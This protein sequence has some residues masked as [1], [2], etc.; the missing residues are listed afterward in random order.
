MKNKIKM[1]ILLVCVA[2]AI[3]SSVIYVS[4]VGN[5]YTLHTN[6]FLETDRVPETEVK[7]SNESVVQMTEARMENGELIFEFET[8]KPGKTTFNINYKYDN[9]IPMH[10]RTFEVNSFGTLIDRT[11]GNIRFN[12]FKFILYASLAVLFVVQFIMLWIFSDYRKEGNFS[13]PM[14]ACGGIGI[15]NLV[16][17]AYILYKMLH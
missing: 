6:I 4:A 2:T 13:Y 8:L 15:Y 12:G 3:I 11:D 1:L 9:F 16:L 5:H 17:F 10:E 14:I 7:L